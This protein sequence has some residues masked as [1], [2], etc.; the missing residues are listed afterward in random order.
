MP[1]NFIPQ[2]LQKHMEGIDTIQESEPNFEQTQKIDLNK[3]SDGSLDSMREEGEGQQLFPIAGPTRLQ[4]DVA[5]QG[6]Q[7]LRTIE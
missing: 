3:L 1:T 7:H 2:S 5:L 6:E 4:K